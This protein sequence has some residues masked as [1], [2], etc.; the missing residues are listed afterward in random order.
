MEGI[1]WA[2]SK[3]DELKRSRGISFEEILAEELVAN[4]N[5]PARAHQNYLLFKIKDY[6]WAVPYVADGDGIFLKTLF[7]SRKYTKLWKK[8][9]LT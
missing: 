8:G 7:P 9:E 5:H 2:T 3:S 4:V 6:I 1:R